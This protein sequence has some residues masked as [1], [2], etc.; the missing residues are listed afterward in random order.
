MLDQFSREGIV[1]DNA[2]AFWMYRAHQA[3]RNESYREFRER[4]IELTPEQW[5]I[6]VRL[7]EREGRSQNDLCDSTF[8]DR[9]TMSRI[10]DGMERRKLIVRRADPNDKR[11]RLVYLTAVGQSLEKQLVPVAR[12]IVTRALRGVSREDLHTTRQTLRR[13]FENLES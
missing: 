7:W 8:R 5:M 11:S 2:L 3:L 9:P 6:L 13:I 1:L 10:L 4:G 12:K